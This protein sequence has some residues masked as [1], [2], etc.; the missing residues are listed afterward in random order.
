MLECRAF[1]V[2]ID[3][4]YLQPHPSRNNPSN[5]DCSQLHFEKGQYI[6]THWNIWVLILTWKL[7]K[8]GLKSLP[9][10]TASVSNMIRAQDNTGT[11]TQEDK[12]VRF[13]DSLNN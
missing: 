1:I 2:L 13:Y 5:I 8:F 11:I 7:N 10:D 3:G 4:K 9:N 12:T 6:A